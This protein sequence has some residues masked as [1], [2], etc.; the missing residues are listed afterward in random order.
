M[1]ETQDVGKYE[2]VKVIEELG[3]TIELRPFTPFSGEK[4]WGKLCLMDDGKHSGEVRFRKNTE[5]N[6]TIREKIAGTK[7]TQDNSYLAWAILD[8]SVIAVA[9]A[10]A[11]ERVPLDKLKHKIDSFGPNTQMKFN[12]ALEMFGYSLS[13]YEESVKASGIKPKSNKPKS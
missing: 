5:N 1:N 13:Q 4:N 10:V 8:L 11:T 12:D 3:Y 9:H 2:F 7:K 6:A